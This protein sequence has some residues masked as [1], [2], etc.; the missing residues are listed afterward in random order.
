MKS[1]SSLSVNINFFLL[2]RIERRRRGSQF[3][4]WQKKEGSHTKGSFDRSPL[5]PSLPPSLHLRHLSPPYFFPYFCWKCRKK[6]INP[7]RK[8]NADRSAHSHAAD[9]FF[10]CPGRKLKHFPQPLLSPL[11]NITVVDEP[12]GN[13]LFSF[14]SSPSSPFWHHRL[15]VFV[16]SVHKPP[17]FFPFLS[18]IN[19]FLFVLSPLARHPRF[20][21]ADAE[22]SNVRTRFSPPLPLFLFLSGQ[23]SRHASASEQRGETR[24]RYVKK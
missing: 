7:K 23:P 12:Q 6:K 1:S 16:T 8:K 9:F 24:Q 2:G 14:F 4:Q 15:L 5:A 17:S 20:K 10:R 22:M 13:S 21:T 18:P 11:K 3:V 19:P